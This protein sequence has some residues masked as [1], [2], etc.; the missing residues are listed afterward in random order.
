MINRLWVQL[1]AGLLSS[2]YCLDR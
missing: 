2:A 1:P